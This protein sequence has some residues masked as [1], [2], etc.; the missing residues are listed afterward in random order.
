LTECLAMYIASVTV[1]KICL[2]IKA[3]FVVV[4]V[5]FV[6]TGLFLF[7]LNWSLEKL[8]IKCH[9]HWL[10]VDVTG[11]V[12]STFRLVRQTVCIC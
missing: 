4:Q 7:V 11:I 1:N 8:H 2:L 3:V 6:K 12:M 9:R 10:C 5:L